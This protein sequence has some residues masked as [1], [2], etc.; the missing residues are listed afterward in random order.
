M[1]RFERPS[2]RLLHE[3]T[4]GALMLG[5]HGDILRHLLRL[6]H[7]RTKLPLEP[8][9]F[10]FARFVRFH[11]FILRRSSGESRFRP[12]KPALRRSR[13]FILEAVWAALSCSYDPI[14]HSI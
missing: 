8:T 11:V 13:P 2:L 1:N 14:P 10:C 6:P 7:E 4:Q 5:N 12:Q 9:D 3:M